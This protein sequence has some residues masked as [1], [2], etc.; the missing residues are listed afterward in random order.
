MSRDQFSVER[1]ILSESA[2]FARFR[3]ICMFCI[4]QNSLLACDKGIQHILVGFRRP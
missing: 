3:G 2:E 4:M 1:G